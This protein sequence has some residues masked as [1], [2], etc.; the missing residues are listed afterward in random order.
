MIYASRAFEA[1]CTDDCDVRAINYPGRLMAEAGLMTESTK[2]DGRTADEQD[3]FDRIRA[4]L[5][6]AFA[7]PDSAY[8]AMTADEV[9]A[10]NATA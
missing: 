4:E 8:V 2:V 3:A 7:A 6:R 5:D 9:I 10:R 1:R